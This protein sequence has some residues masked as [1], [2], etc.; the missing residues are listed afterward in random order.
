MAT[1]QLPDAVHVSTGDAEIDWPAGAVTPTS[2]SEERILAG[3]VARGHATLL[4]HAP[5]P[6]EPA[7]GED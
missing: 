4:T 6:A 7:D 1:Y 2:E 5:D 3:M